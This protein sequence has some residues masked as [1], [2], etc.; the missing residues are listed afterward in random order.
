MKMVLSAHG[1][2]YVDMKLGNKC[3]LVRVMCNPADSTQ[4]IPD[5]NKLISSSSEQLQR[6]IYWNKNELGGYNW[7]KNNKSYWDDI[8][9]QLHNL[10]H[11]HIIGGEP[12]Y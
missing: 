4:W 12:N 11:I 7:W 5:Y 1:I 6:E 8:Y 2:H 10:K 9:K 3:D